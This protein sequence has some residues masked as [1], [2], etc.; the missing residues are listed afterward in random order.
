VTAHT[1]D[2]E[3]VFTDEKI[4]MPQS[5]AYGRGSEMVYGSYK[6]AGLLRDTSLQPGQTRIETF[7]IRLPEKVGKDGKPAGP[8]EIHTTVRLWYVPRGVDLKDGIPGKDRFLFN[9]ET[10]TV[11][12]E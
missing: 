3:K 12:M 7:E 6:K 5:P 11:S 4:Y 1:E 2:G 10:S 8:R 9:E